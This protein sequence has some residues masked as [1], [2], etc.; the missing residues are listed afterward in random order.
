MTT[1]TVPEVIVR[2]GERIDP[3]EIEAVL[4]G[5]PEVEDVSVAGQPSR[6]WGETV[7]AVVRLRPRSYAT[8]EELHAYCREHLAR[9]KAPSNWVFTTLPS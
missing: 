1:S 3:R 7:A 9:Y 2:G 6:M 5:H 4:R 8:R